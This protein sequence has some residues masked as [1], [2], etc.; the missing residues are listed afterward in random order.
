MCGEAARRERPCGHQHRRADE[1]VHPGQR[2]RRR[3][4]GE[5]GEDSGVQRR[6][7]GAGEL[8]E[9]AECAEECTSLAGRRDVGEEGLEG[10]DADTAD[11]DN[12]DGG[13]EAC[14]RGGGARAAETGREDSEPVEDGALKACS[15]VCVC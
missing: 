11:R 6:A 15:R 3:L 2:Q 12:D 14:G 5:G 1:E 7:D 8:G 13:E 4:G 9:G 10:G